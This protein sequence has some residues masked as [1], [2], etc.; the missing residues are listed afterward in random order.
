MQ[1]LYLI[2]KTCNFLSCSYCISRSCKSPCFCAENKSIWEEGSLLQ[3]FKEIEFG[4]YVLSY[5]FPRQVTRH[6][7]NRSLS[8]RCLYFCPDVTAG[9]HELN[10]QMPSQGFGSAKF[11]SLMF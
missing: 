8:R 9:A 7:S 6:L 3:Q 11:M 2:K 1:L 5:H 10:L 4:W